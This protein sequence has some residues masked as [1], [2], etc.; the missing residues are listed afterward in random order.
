M[1][2]HCDDECGILKFIP[3]NK[4]CPILDMKQKRKDGEWWLEGKDGNRIEP[5]CEDKVVRKTKKTI[6]MLC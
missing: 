1:A 2:R 3:E 6:R 5:L 4:N